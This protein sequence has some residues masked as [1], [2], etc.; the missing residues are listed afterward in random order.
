[1]E[2]FLS[3]EDWYKLVFNEGYAAGRV[4]FALII[5]AMCIELI[6][7]RMQKKLI[8]GKKLVSVWH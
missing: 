5:F 3:T 7:Y 4:A 1:M 8:L 6:A 2:W